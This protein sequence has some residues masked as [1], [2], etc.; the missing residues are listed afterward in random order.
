M[1]VHGE[2]DLLLDASDNRIE[3]VHITQT[4]GYPVGNICFLYRSPHNKSY[5]FTGDT[6][7]QWDGE[8]STL[9][10]PH[11]GGHLVRR[12]VRSASDAA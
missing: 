12:P 4:A 5:L 7:F 9:V 6:I 3:D 1:P 8:W 11:S 2:L 10:L